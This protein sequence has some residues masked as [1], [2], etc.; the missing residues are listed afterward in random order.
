MKNLFLLIILTVLPSEIIYSQTITYP[1]KNDSSIIQIKKIF[2]NYGKVFASDFQ[3]KDITLPGYSHGLELKESD[4]L[5]AEEILSRNVPVQ[6]KIGHNIK[7][8]KY[9]WRQYFGYINLNGDKCLFIHL[10]RYNGKPSIVSY[11]YWK[12][13]VSI[14]LEEWDKHNTDD[15]IIYLNTNTIKLNNPDYTE[16]PIPE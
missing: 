8:F 16:P 11:D 7:H 6:N 5:N 3:P 1:N 9:R 2:K 14:V 10:E 4:I 12:T 13:R 15:F